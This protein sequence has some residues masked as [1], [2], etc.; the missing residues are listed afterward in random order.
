MRPSVWPSQSFFR[1]QRCPFVASFQG[2]LFVALVGIYCSLQYLSLPDATVLTFLAPLCTG[3]AG[4]FFLGET[5]TR[6]QAL[7][8]VFSL[9][10]VV[11]IARPA[12][13]FGDYSNLWGAGAGFL[14]EPNENVTSAE[15]LFAVC[16]AMLGVSGTTGAF[17]L[18]RAIGKRAHP[19]HYLICYSTLYVVVSSVAMLATKTQFVIPT[20]QGWLLASFG[21]FGF[22]AQVFL[23]MGLQ[24]ETAGRGTM[25]VYTQI[26]FATVLDQ[27][28]FHSVPSTLSVIG[29]LIILTSTLYVAYTKERGKTAHITCD[30]PI[31]E[32]F[33]E[34]FLGRTQENQANYAGNDQDWRQ[35]GR[36]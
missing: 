8:G 23:T 2:L 32:S 12:T 15:R 35:E 18:I 21:I 3:V 19:L 29:T 31:H 36:T 20:G 14:R 4:A 30:Q 26:V 11:L 5:F 13:I 1:T 24:R 33:E 27:I 25:A 6:R 16:M 28:F 34:G 22:L 9:A 17:V 10:G 7:A